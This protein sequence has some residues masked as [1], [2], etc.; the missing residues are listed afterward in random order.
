VTSGPEYCFPDPVISVEFRADPVRTLRPGI[1]SAFHAHGFQMFS[2]IVIRRINTC[3]KIDS[4]LGK[5]SS[6]LER[7]IVV[8]GDVVDELGFCDT[9]K[10]DCSITIISFYLLPEL[11]E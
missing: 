3:S 5:I 11:F 6:L 4:F 1:W 9:K 2:H 8:A 7:L 10:E